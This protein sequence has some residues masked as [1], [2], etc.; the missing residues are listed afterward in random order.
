MA[1]AFRIT[2]AMDKVEASSVTAGIYP[3]IKKT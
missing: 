1:Q 2:R 3:L